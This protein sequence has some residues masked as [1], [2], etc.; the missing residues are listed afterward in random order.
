MNAQS[1]KKAAFKWE[2]PFNLEAE[3]TED[4]RLIRDTAREYCQH[5]LLPRVKEAFR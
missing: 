2:D 1:A 3:L 4:E 5:K